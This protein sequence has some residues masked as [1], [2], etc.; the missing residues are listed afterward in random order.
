MQTHSLNSYQYGEKEFRDVV[1]FFCCLGISLVLLAGLLVSEAS[2][3]NYSRAQQNRTELSQTLNSMSP[4][5]RRSAAQSLAT[6]D[7]GFSSDSSFAVLQGAWQ[8]DAQHRTLV[9]KLTSVAATGQPLNLQPLPANHSWWTFLEVW[10]PATIIG[11]GLLFGLL[12]FLTYAYYC[13]EHKE[14][15]IALDHDGMRGARWWFFTYTALPIGW[16]FYLISYVA[17]RREDNKEYAKVCK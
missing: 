7:K 3:G 6:L 14:R 5:H 11:F 13:G 4:G 8:T 2:Y 12:D 1:K 17:A 10:V 16:I 15:L 9:A